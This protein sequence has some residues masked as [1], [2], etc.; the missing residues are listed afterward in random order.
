MKKIVFILLLFSASAEAQSLFRLV[1]GVMVKLSPADSSTLVN[2]WRDNFIADS[3]AKPYELIKANINIRVSKIQLLRAYL[4]YSIASD[5]QFETVDANLTNH[6]QAYLNGSNR[7]IEW[8]KGSNTATYGNF[9]L[10]GFPSRAY[11]TVQMQTDLL[12]ILQ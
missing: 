1:N 11:F 8:I 10:T 7:L 3:L 12:N 5:S 6:I 4:R 2:E 9:T